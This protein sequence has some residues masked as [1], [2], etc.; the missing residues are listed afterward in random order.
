V[1]QPVRVATLTY[2]AVGT[3]EDPSTARFSVSPAR[4]REQLEAIA[5]AGARPVSIDGEL[6]DEKVFMLS[7]DDGDSSA[8]EV[9][10]PSLASHDWPAHF[11]VVTAGIGS[12]GS[13]S[14]DAVRELR[15]A[16]HVV[17]SHSHTHPRL[18]RV[19]ETE[20]AD[21]WAR[22]RALLEDLLG[23]P[24]ES[25]SIPYGYAPQ[26]VIEAACVA[27]YRHVFT[28]EP[29]TRPENVDGSNVYGRFSVISD[30]PA[31]RV[32][33]IATFS[34]ATLVRERAFWETRRVAKLM[35]G[36]AFEQV[37]DR[38]LAGRHG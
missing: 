26:R 10:A 12:P 13:V 31:E 1:S 16:G 32:A 4:F 15:A 7:F 27:G 5:R 28:S 2:H 29:R 17:G 25:A 33:A 3:A 14:R 38:L 20:L 24:V 19:D 30:T 34:R 22:S 6:P 8:I 23:E 35:L 36:P 9:V 11:F 21:E 18:D 37:R